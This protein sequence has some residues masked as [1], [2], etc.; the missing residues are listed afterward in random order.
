MKLYR[1]IFFLSLIFLIACQ[2]DGDELTLNDLQ[3]S[4]IRQSNQFKFTAKVELLD[5]KTN[6]VTFQDGDSIFLIRALRSQEEMILS[7][8]FLGIGSF[9]G[10]S[11]PNVYITF[12]D[13]GKRYYSTNNFRLSSDAAILIT[14][15]DTSLKTFSASFSGTLYDLA[16][17][18]PEAKQNQVSIKSGELRNVS[19]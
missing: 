4:E 2:E 9:S 19:Y 6:A 8:P 3:Q 12:L 1:N 18:N 11:D 7:I 15:I 5:F 14:E 17:S 13:Q 10:S 16:S